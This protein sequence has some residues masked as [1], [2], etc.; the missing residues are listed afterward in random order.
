MTNVVVALGNTEWEPQF[1]SALGHPMLNVSIQ[2]R[3]LDAIDVRSAIRVLEV[4]AVLLSD[5]TLRVNEDCINDLRACNVQVIAVSN[6]Q[7]WWNSL[8]VDNVV[9]L[10]T[11]NLGASIHQLVGLFRNHAPEVIRQTEPKGNFITVTGFG[12]GSGRTTVARELAYVSAVASKRST[13]LVDADVISPSLAIELDDDNVASGLLPLV[14]LA[15]SK[16]LSVEASHNH[17]T[18]VLEQLELIRGLP[19]ASRWTDLRAHALEEL[20]LHLGQSYESVIVD[21]GP[22]LCDEGA[23]SSMGIVSRRSAAHSTAIEAST[24]VVLSARA[25]NVGIA[26]LV[27]GYLDNEEHLASKEISVVLSL[28]SDV[29][30]QAVQ[31]VRRLTG[32]HSVSV[33]KSSPVFSRA[34]REH[35]FASAFDRQILNDFHS[36][37]CETQI[38]LRNESGLTRQRTFLKG[39]RNSRAA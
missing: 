8:G 18:P 37:F 4:D 11:E 19:A 22:V 27:R 28:G 23:E 14:R 31:T 38:D 35:S 13:V 12:G 20:W 10:D 24:H 3:C 2:R 17:L 33:I 39:I 1:I 26:R 9:A 21:A 30:K 6:D 29:N 7:Q 5:E 36:F 15:E 32:I 25:D 34:T 16:K